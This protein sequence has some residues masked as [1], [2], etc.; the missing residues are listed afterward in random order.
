MNKNTKILL[1]VAA[2]AVAGYL[3]WRWW[4]G[5]KAAGG[6]TSSPTGSFG[7]NLNSVAPELVGGSSGPTAGPAVDLP[8]NI[9]LTTQATEPRRSSELDPGEVAPLGHATTD[10]IPAPAS[11]QS[12][13]DRANP[14]VTDVMNFEGDQEAAA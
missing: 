12:A 5:R 8:V 3:G 14:P 7:T 11:T 10:A 6:D 2:V 13:L 9:T 1:I 4:Q